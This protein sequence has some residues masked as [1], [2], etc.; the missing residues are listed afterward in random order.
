MSQTERRRAVNGFLSRTRASADDPRV[1]AALEAYLDAA[2]RGQPPDRGEF[3]ARYPEV[4]AELARCLD[5]LEFVRAAAPHLDAQEIGRPEAASPQTLGDFRL[6]REVG[7]GGMG[8]VYEAEQISLGRRVALKVLPFTTALDPRQLQRFKN[9]AQAAAQLQHPHIVPVHAVG[10]ERGVPYYAMQFIDGQNL[11]EVLAE[12]RRRRE[13]RG[14]RVEGRGSKTGAASTVVDQQRETERP[15]DLRSSTLDPRSSIFHPRSS[16]F[17]RAVAEL[18]VQAAEALDYAHQCG[19]VHRDVKPANLLLDARGHLWVT[20]FGLARFP[21]EGGVTR[22]GDVLGTLRYMSPEQAQARNG[23]VDHRSDLYALGAT[24]YEL[25]TLEPVFDGDDPQEILVQTALRE[26]RAL[27]H[28]DRTIPVELETI[29]LKTLEKDPARRYQTAQ[30]LADDLRRFLEHKPIHARR[31][32]LG[33][34]AVK[35][36]RRHP[37]AVTAALAVGLVT[38][39]ASVFSAVVFRRGQQEAEQGRQDARQAFDVMYTRVAEEWLAHQPRHEAVQKELLVRVLN[40]YQRLVRERPADAASRHELGRAH[41]RIGEIEH[42]LGQSKAALEAYAQAVALLDALAA[43]FPEQPA[44]RLSLAEA[45]AGRGYVLRDLRRYAEAEGT[46]R[47]ALARFEKLAAD[48][49]DRPEAA[50]GLAGCQNNLALILQALGR[51][52]DAEALFR[53]ARQSFAHLAAAHP[54]RPGYRHDLASSHNGLAHLLRDAGRREEAEQAYRQA[55]DLWQ[56]LV[57]QRP[58][59]P[60]YRQAL[61]VARH[62]LGILLGADKRMPEAEAAYRQALALQQKLADD[63][64]AVPAYRR[65]MAATQNGLAA[66]LVLAG[67]PA[68]AEEAYRQALAVRKQLVAEFQEHPDY[69]EDLAATYDGLG[70]LL[71]ALGRQQEA[72]DAFRAAKDA[73][74]PKTP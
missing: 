35:W 13:G 23:L 59:R 38:V 25:L 52:A 20:D 15:G 74:G 58:D 72:D 40:F 43:E 55:L 3:L 60:V 66:L 33:D 21:G 7:R 71:T 64:P 29:V 11:A 57:A 54:D 67:R 2:E 46:Y 68:E 32:S 22:S 63:F 16:A 53:Q 14:S 8:L 6:V 9:E 48:A 28:L 12:L 44:Y 24:L 5:G 45:L 36:A 19:V 73:R 70:Q 56:Q 31:P 62:N 39:A 27:R 4:A 47:Q 50:D 51:S 1:V 26:P 61:G 17:F 49:P 42:R 41:Q 34:R 10:T 37:S 69:R 18:G 30:D 65:D